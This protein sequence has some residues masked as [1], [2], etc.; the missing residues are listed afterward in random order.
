MCSVTWNPCVCYCPLSLFSWSTFVWETVKKSFTF[1]YLWNKRNLNLSDIDFYRATAAATG[2]KC[3]ENGHTQHND[4]VEHFS[5]IKKW[6]MAFRSAE[7]KLIFF[8][9]DHSITVHHGSAKKEFLCSILQLSIATASK[10]SK[11]FKIWSS[12]WIMHSLL[13]LVFRCRLRLYWLFLIEL[14]QAL[15]FVQ[16]FILH[17]FPSGLHFLD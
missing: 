16:I 11:Q 5:V 10:L 17:A 13:Q 1:Y 6:L 12:C 14:G 3:T 7:C 4:S 15:W 2:A 8:S 9:V